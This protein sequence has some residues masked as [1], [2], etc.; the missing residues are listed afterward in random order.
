MGFRQLD[1]VNGTTPRK[2]PV[3]SDH[4]SKYQLEHAR[5]TRRFGLLTN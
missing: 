3:N 5:E 1:T 4:G 2:I